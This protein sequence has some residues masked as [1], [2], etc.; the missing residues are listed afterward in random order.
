MDGERVL[1]GGSYDNRDLL[2]LGALDSLKFQALAPVDESGN[3]L[4]H[5]RAFGRRQHLY[6]QTEKALFAL[7]MRTL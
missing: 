6:M 2:F 7:D 3:R 1:M 5:F 4:T